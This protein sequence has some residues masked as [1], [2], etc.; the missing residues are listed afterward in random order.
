F[1]SVPYALQARD[2]E[3][4]G[5]LPP[6][7][8]LRSD[9]SVVGISAP[10]TPSS[11]TPA[12][13]GVPSTPG[14]QGGGAPLAHSENVV[15]KFLSSGSLG[16]SQINDANGVGSLQNLEHFVFADRFD[17]ADLGAKINAAILSLGATGG[18]VIIPAG[19]YNNVATTV[20]IKTANISIVG[21]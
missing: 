7:A 10:P 12:V 4:L 17:G 5:G 15:P 8:F 2:S 18:M 1:A 20:F 19:V 21:S 11:Q 13:Y 3:T 14:A 6:S 9:P 16:D